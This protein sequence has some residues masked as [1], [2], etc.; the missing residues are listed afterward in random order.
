MQSSIITSADTA[1]LSTVLADAPASTPAKRARKPRAAKP[2]ATD[3]VTTDAA[4]AKPIKLTAEQRAEAKAA[5]DTAKLEAAATAKAE[6]EAAQ[7]DKRATNEQARTERAE[8][9]SGFRSLASAFYAGASLAAHRAKPSPRGVYSDRVLNPAQRCRDGVLTGRDESGL[10]L[11]LSGASDTGSF[12]P[13]A[14]AFDVGILSR[15][16]SVDLV[17]FA[18]DTFSLSD[19]GRERATAIVKRAAR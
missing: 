1:A 9:I 12:D 15:L 16:A 5:R 14:L 6:R 18:N 8:Q 4:P 19:T 7:A 10:A 17:T 11:L 3:N 2:A 13:C